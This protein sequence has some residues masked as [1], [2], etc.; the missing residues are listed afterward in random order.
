MTCTRYHSL[1]VER[2][3]L[4]ACLEVSAWTDYMDQQGSLARQE[5]ALERVGINP[6]PKQ[7]TREDFA[8]A[9]QVLDEEAN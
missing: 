9:A 2:E 5:A 6:D 1:I 4:P 7:W 3:S 8:R